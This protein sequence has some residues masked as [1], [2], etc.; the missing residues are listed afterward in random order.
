[1][2]IL[3]APELE[4]QGWRSSI[5]KVLCILEHSNMNP[6]FPNSREMKD[7]VFA[8]LNVVGLVLVQSFFAVPQYC[9]WEWECLLWAIVY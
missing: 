2:C 7:L 8:L 5:T 3:Q 1:M 4:E 9:L 6:E